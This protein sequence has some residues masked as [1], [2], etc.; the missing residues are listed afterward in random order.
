MQQEQRR[1]HHYLQKT[2]KRRKTRIQEKVNNRTHALTMTLHTFY[3]T[4]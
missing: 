2:T 4:R 1:D 3:D